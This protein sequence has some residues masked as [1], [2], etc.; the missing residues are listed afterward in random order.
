MSNFDDLKNKLVENDFN[1]RDSNQV[2]FVDSTKLFDSPLY[3]KTTNVDGEYDWSDIPNNVDAKSVAFSVRFDR[4]DEFLSGK[5]TG[6]SD[7]WDNFFEE[8][9]RGIDECDNVNDFADLFMKKFFSGKGP[10]VELIPIHDNEGHHY[11]YVEDGNH[12]IT[13]LLWLGYTFSKDDLKKFSL[14]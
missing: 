1:F 10:S 6:I 11:V 2:L 5:F 8:I 7:N 13:F 3:G 4:Y 14:K 9:K 12:R